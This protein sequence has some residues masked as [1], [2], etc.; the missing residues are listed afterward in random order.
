MVRITR[1]MLERQ[2]DLLCEQFNFP[3]NKHFKEL[4]MFLNWDYG[5]PQIQEHTTPYPEKGWSGVSCPF[6]YGRGTKRE[7]FDQL[8]FA[9]QVAYRLERNKEVTV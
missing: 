8:Y 4:G 1:E 6:G 7:M 9:R 3:R 5:K 2:L